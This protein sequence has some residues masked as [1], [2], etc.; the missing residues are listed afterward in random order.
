MVFICI[1][2]IIGDIEHLFIYLLAICISSL[3]KCSVFCP[4]SNQ[5]VCLM[6][7]C[8]TCL[9]MLHINLLS[10]A[11]ILSHSTG[12]LFFLLMVSSVVQKFLFN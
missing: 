6:L 1:S 7:S 4:F 10:F 2:L 8:M 11:N 9:Y 5:V 3:E 12:C